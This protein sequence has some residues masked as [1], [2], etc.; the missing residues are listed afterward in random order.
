MRKE[1]SAGEAMSRPDLKDE[2]LSRLYDLWAGLRCDRP[3]PERTAFTPEI[4]KPWLGNLLLI[5]VGEDGRYRYRLYGSNFVYRFGVEM[6]KRTI[7]DLPPE[8]S[9]A[10]RRDYDSVV[11]T[12]QPLS[13]LYTSDFEIVDVNRKVGFQRPETWE[14]L[15]LP[16]ANKGGET[17]AMLMVGAYQLPST[18]VGPGES[19]IPF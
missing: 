17:A 12:L 16:L 9:A 1:L 5:D 14:R 18:G 6:T 10:I 3:L 15:V 11:R 13:R 2:K 4:L 8:Q 19:P 7:D